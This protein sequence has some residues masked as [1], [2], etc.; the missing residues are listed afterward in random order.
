MAP[1]CSPP[2]NMFANRPWRLAFGNWF[3]GCPRIRRGKFLRSERGTICEGN[4]IHATA[5]CLIRTP[6]MRR[7]AVQW[8]CPRAELASKRERL[9]LQSSDREK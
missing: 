1:R 4:F 8:D 7:T 5:R 2:Y 3:Y 6:G 9:S